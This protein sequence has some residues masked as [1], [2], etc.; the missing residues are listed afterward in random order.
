MKSRIFFSLIIILSIAL[1]FFRI[2]T[3]PNG[4]YSDEIVYA[5]NAYS[6][7][8]TGNDEYGMRFPLAFTSFGDYKTPLYIYFF[9]PFIAV[10][11]MNDLGTRLPSAVLGIVS[12]ALIFQLTKTMGLG[13]RTAL[14]S[15][16][17]MAVLPFALQFHRMAHENTLVM[18]LVVSGLLF[19][20]RSFTSPKYLVAAAVVFSL[21][22]YTYHD[23]RVFIP[24]FL[25]LLGLIYRE[26]L[27]K[28]IPTTLVAAAV[29]FLMLMPL[30]GVFTGEAAWSRPGRTIIF[31]DRG[32]ISAIEAERR[33]DSYADESVGRVFHNKPVNFTMKFFEN[34]LMHFSPQ[35]LFFSGDPVKIYHT[36]GSGVLLLVTAPALLLGLAYALTGRVSHARLLIGWLF[37]AP[38]ASSLTRFVPSASRTLLMVP[39]LS[40]F[41]AIG[42]RVMSRHVRPTGWY[43]VFLFAISCCF[44]LNFS[45]YLHMYYVHTPNVYAKEWHYGMKEVLEYVKQEQDR[46]R[47]IWFGKEAWGY[48]YP[49]Y[50]LQ[51]PPEKYQKQ[52]H[53]SEL[54]EFGFGWVGGFDKYIFDDIPQEEFLPDT[55]YIGIPSDFPPDMPSKKTVYYPNGETAFVIVDSQSVQRPL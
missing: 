19:F 7:L 22:M 6:I 10:F 25:L 39:V 1:R 40:M 13:N 21:S 14:L 44:I 53:L 32:I 11:G 8:T 15:A 45:Y 46:Y 3:I 26:H 36:I 17:F 49:L 35:F 34:Y 55:L 41:I 4:I 16:F 18:V 51:Y 43:R 54:N 52:A 47:E 28:Q 42:L 31:S 38:V 9:V 12:V 50:Y 29:F 30:L 23:A 27:Y 37:L 2:G 24:L 33:I 5:Y 48:L 20:F